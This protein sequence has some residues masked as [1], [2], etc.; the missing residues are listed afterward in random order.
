MSNDAYHNPWIPDAARKILAGTRGT[1]LDVGGS[2]PYAGATHILDILGYDPEGLLRKCWGG[3]RDRGNVWSPEQYTVHDLCSDRPW[4]FRDRQFDLGLCSHTLED[5]RNPRP[6]LR[7]LAR[8]CRRAL[9]IAPSRLL[10]QCRNADHPR[11]IGFRHHRWMVFR[12]GAKLVLRE[13]TAEVYR[14]GA[15]LRCPLGKRLR[16]E[17]GSMYF[18]GTLDDW[19]TRSF[20]SR[21]Q[22]REEYRAFVRRTRIVPGL[23]EPDGYR[24]DARYWAWKLRQ[25]LLGARVP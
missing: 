10:E 25:I 19:E 18:Y 12:E 17:A 13:K 15:H 11:I 14:H 20:A 1:I 4:P 6:A 2:A 16:I 7:E 5:V 3:R 21:T 8:V 24:H 22:D 9:V 23:F